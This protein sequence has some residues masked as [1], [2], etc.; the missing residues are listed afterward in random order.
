MFVLTPLA[1][2]CVCADVAVAQ[3]LCSRM[4]PA[5]PFY[6][7]CCLEGVA[8]IS[9][10]CNGSLIL[11]C[12]IVPLATSGAMHR[13]DQHP[14][15]S[16]RG[17][18]THFETIARP[19]LTHRASL[20]PPPLTSPSQICD[21]NTNIQVKYVRK[22]RCG[23]ARIADGSTATRRLEGHKGGSGGRAKGRRGGRSGGTL[24]VVSS[25]D[26]SLPW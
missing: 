5:P 4:S 13:H 12:A 6:V 8:I 1:A 7:H 20:T 16:K 9:L 25:L 15:W 23:E 10:T 18:G 22:Q 24:I 14:R 21:L 2:H 3:C 17:G 11:A 19:S 26:W